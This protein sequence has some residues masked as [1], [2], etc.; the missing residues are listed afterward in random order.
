MDEQIGQ[1]R[2]VEQIITQAFGGG[3][4]QVF[5][6]VRVLQVGVDQQYRVVNFHGDAGGEI[7]RGNGFAFSRARAGDGEHIPVI[8]LESLQGLGAEHFVGVRERALFH[9]GDDAVFAQVVVR[10]F[11]VPGLRVVDINRFNS[12]W[13]ISPVRMRK[14]RLASALCAG[15]FEGLFDSFHC[16]YLLL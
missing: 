7:Q 3:D 16:N 1:R 4:A 14:S 13:R 10:E 11:G 12:G 6:Q 9:A 5:V 2:V 15:A 8:F